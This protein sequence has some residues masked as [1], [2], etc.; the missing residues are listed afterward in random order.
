MNTRYAPPSAEVADVTPQGEHVLAGRGIRLAAV[1]IDGA[2]L[3]GLF[4]VIG[5][6]SPLNI[7]GTEMAQAG[8]AARLGVQVLSLALFAAI[9]GWLLARSGQTIGKMLLGIRIVRG[10][11]SAATLP[12][13]LALRY[14]V[15]YLAA[16]L[17]TALMLIF[18]LVDALMI[19]RA[20][21][22]CLHDLIAD[23]IVI[24]A[25]PEK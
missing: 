7:F 12:R 3:I 18:S 6:F 10:D 1:L 16:A 24:K 11:G 19:L 14:G 4:W 15:G 25:Q 2:I 21:R 22:R 13:L 23:T 20:D 17:G 8:L 9:N 5:Q